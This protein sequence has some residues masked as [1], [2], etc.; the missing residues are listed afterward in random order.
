MTAP[1]CRKI[2][3]ATLYLGDSMRELARIVPP[4]ATVLDPFMGSGTT[5]VGAVMEGR[6]FIGIECDPHHFEVACRRIEE[7]QCMRGV[8]AQ[9]PRDA[10]EIT[11]Q[12]ADLL[13]G[14][15]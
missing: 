2:G 6:K 3:D 8:F 12:Q 13:E 4:G 7:A 15:L 11:A 1:I 14:G 5:G 9:D 10:Y